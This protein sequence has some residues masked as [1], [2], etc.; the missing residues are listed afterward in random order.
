MVLSLFLSLLVTLLTGGA[1]LAKADVTKLVLK[2]E[3]ESAFGA[4]VSEPDVVK[5][6]PPLGGVQATYA[7]SSLPIKTF[8]LTLRTDGDIAPSLKA[9]GMTA[10]SLYRQT[11]SQPTGKVETLAINGGEG[12]YC[13]SSAHVLKNNV[14]L[15]TSTFFG[16][17]PKAIAVLKDLTTKAANRL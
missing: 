7:T 3:V 10:A 17:S 12:F 8:A 13:G 15:S 16:R 9:T 6:S 1:A 11:K 4:T 14:Y 2:S 5:N